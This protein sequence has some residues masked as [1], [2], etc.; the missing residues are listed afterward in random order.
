MLDT[1]ILVEEIAEVP[2]DPL[3]DPEPISVTIELGNTD[4]TSSLDASKLEID[5]DMAGGVCN[6][7]DDELTTML[8]PDPD[9]EPTSAEDELSMTGV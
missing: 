1:N 2:S 9:P 4:G 7:N 5:E 6:G 3:P 8:S